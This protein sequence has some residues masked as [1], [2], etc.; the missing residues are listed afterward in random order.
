MSD[1]KKDGKGEGGKRERK[2][3]RWV[4]FQTREPAQ[5]T[6]AVRA[7]ASLRVK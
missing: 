6:A 7:E 2:E 3:V 1:R 4:R 5:Q